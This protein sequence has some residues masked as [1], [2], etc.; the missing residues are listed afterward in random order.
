MKYVQTRVSI[1]RLDTLRHASKQLKQH[2]LTGIN[3]PM[4]D[5]IASVRMTASRSCV[6]FEG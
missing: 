3:Y 4:T 2:Y 1:V 6:N 5:L